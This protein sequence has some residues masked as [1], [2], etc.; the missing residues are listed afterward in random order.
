MPTS[1]YPAARAAVAAIR[2]IT[3]GRGAEAVFDMVGSDATLQL[4][5]GVVAVNG[6]IGLVGLAGGSLAVS[7]LGLPFGLT[8][9]PTYWGTLPELHEVLELAA[10]GDLAAHKV[11]YPLG[12]AD[13]A[14]AAVRAG[15]VLGRAVVV[16]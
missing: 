11:A 3:H 9:T 15:T 12:R 8:V 2:E 16:P 13:E 7:L 5:G 1:S 4:A 6:H 14:Y 10:R